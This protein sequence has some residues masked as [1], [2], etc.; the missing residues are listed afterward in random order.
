L[1]VLDDVNSIIGVI[2]SD[3][4]LRIIHKQSGLDL[5]A[6]AGVQE[7]ASV[8]DDAL[9]KVKHRYKWLILN[10]FTAFIAAAVVSLFQDT[11]QALV[12]LAVY[13]P[14]VAGMGG[15]A[16]VQALAVTVRGLTLKEIDLKHCKKAV[17]N[18]ITAG[19]INGIIVGTLVAIIASLFNKSPM[20]GL[21][22]GMSMIINLMIAGFFGSMAPLLMKA[23]GKDPAT[24][25]TIF[26]TTAT[27]VFGFFV[28]LGMAQTLV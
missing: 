10:L 11:I 20:F 16:G 7:E 18:E 5:Y 19:G 28:F 3:D 2:Y 27:D 12:L 17:F 21:V 4:V 8:L 6:L 1:V 13:M 15:N 9:V 24:S 26:I 22:L 14:V 23:L 25:A